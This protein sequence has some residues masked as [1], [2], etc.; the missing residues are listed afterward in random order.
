M[1]ALARSSWMP[2]SFAGLSLIRSD[3][4]YSRTEKCAFELVSSALPSPFVK[5]IVVT[6]FGSTL[7]I[8]RESGSCL[9][10]SKSE[11]SLTSRVTTSVITSTSRGR[12]EYTRNCLKL[13]SFADPEYS[14]VSQRMSPSVAVRAPAVILF[15]TRSRVKPGHINEHLLEAAK[16]ADKFLTLHLH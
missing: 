8:A 3:T 2:Y 5:S 14:T 13:A 10:E 4:R 7:S 1:P 16:R 12:F 6:G 15:L 9:T 11:S